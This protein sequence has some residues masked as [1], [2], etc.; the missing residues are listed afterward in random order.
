V[1]GSEETPRTEV[2]PR[3]EISP[4]RYSPVA[5]LEAI[6]MHN[7]TLRAQIENVELGFDHFESVKNSFRS[8]LSPLSELLEDF[9]ATKKRSH[10]TKMKL[11]LLQDAHD[12]L[13]ARHRATLGEFD[14]A[15][16]DRNAQQRENRELQQRAQRF[17]ASLSETQ[18]ELRDVVAAKEKLERL[19]EI[20]TRQT[21]AHAEEIERFKAQLAAND[22]TIASLELSHKSAGD[23]AILLGQENA[24]LRESWQSLSGSF[25]AASQRI[26]DFES[27]IEQNAHRIAELE[28]ALTNE[29]S[30]H[31]G[32]RARHL[33]HV[34][35]S[36][37]EIAG[38]GNTVQGV[39]GRADVAEKIL[40]EARAQ[41]REK[42][43]E[44]RAAERRLLENGIQ[45][46]ALEKSLRTMKDDLSAAN[47]RIAGSE[48][49][50]LGLADQVNSLGNALK[51]RDTALHS[52][53]AKVEHLTARLDDAAKAAQRDREEWERRTAALRE[54]FEREHAQR[55][56]AEGALQASR[57]ERQQTRRAPTIGDGRGDLAR[58]VED[59]AGSPP[60]NVTQLPRAADFTLPQNGRES[61]AGP[62]GTDAFRPR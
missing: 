35:R 43:D 48:R 23:K 40:A 16:E 7:E 24:T 12:A 59:A 42:I 3:A 56:L 32:L 45:I 47:E 22:Q 60:S 46:D 31:A 10:E 55:N 2:A 41:L 29:Q 53:T 39:R 15:V 9:E 1:I 27:T 62:R 25:D 11:D 30:K 18:G 6:G 33:E 49:L 44:L 21:T 20:E 5:T 26:A 61:A 38:L 36:R 8:L 34:E 28:Q 19:L 17:E 54:A 57:A 50:R 37:A 58:Q 14:S 13:G 51:I 52:A 4:P